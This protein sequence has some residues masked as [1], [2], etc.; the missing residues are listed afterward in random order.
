MNKLNF[1]F[2]DI[3]KVRKGDPYNLIFIYMKQYIYN[4]RCFSKD[5]SVSAIK[6]KLKYMYNLEKIMA[7]KNKRQKHFDTMWNAF[8]V[9]FL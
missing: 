4:S 5:L 2:G 3:S 1:I 8:K 6:E 9:L 7:V